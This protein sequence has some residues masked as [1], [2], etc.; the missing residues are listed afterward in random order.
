MIPIGQSVGDFRQVAPLKILIFTFA[1]ISNAGARYRFYKLAP[2]LRAAGHAVK[3]LPPMPDW[4]FR[5][6]YGPL[7]GK[8]SGRLSARLNAI[9]R[10]A[11]YGGVVWPIR[12]AQIARWSSWA[13]VA[14]VQRE[15]YRPGNWTLERDLR[16]QVRRL[17]WDY[18]DALYATKAFGASRHV[19]AVMAMADLVLAGNE[20]LADYAKARGRPV[21]VVPTCLDAGRYGPRPARPVTGRVVI[22]W[23]GN[24]HNLRHF[25]LI[26][27]ALRRLC[28]DHPDVV[29][30]IVT[31]GQ[32]VDLPGIRFEYRQWS[33]A[34]EIDDL[35]S[36]DI[37]IMPLLDRPYTRGKC[38]FKL[39]QYMAA[40]LP[41]VSSPVGMNA[42]IIRD[43]VDGLL[44]STEAEWVDCLGR[45]AGNP[46]IRARLGAE[47]QRVAAKRFDIRF[48]AGAV[49]DALT[50][51]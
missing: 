31:D 29:L 46:E 18:D 1:P 23:V 35:A 28:S 24:P 16:Q 42:C 8:P 33:L 50:T 47:A 3:V 48:A 30:R 2:L 37:G 12:R 9:V 5:L 32:K 10:A 44:A 25:K 49:L 34:R 7:V 40:G 20:T 6:F 41:T 17:V 27:P 22:G 4:L 19:D 43:G 26:L 14:V 13:D 38:G 45:L 15:L 51:L 21:V 11:L 39:I 36:F